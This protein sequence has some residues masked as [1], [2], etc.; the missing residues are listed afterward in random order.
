VRQEKPRTGNLRLDTCLTCDYRITFLSTLNPIAIMSET[1]QNLSIARI[2]G[3]RSRV[4]DPAPVELG[5][6]QGYF[7]DAATRALLG[8]NKGDFL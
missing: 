6:K 4:N 1:S 7:K 8:L 5:R 3:S 2:P